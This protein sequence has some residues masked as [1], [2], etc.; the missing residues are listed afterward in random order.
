L[1]G[2]GRYLAT[3]LGPPSVGLDRLKHNFGIAAKF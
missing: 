1:T 2:Y 3:R